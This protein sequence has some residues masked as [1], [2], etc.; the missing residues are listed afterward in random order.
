MEA[1]DKTAE[2]II[3]IIINYLTIIFTTF[4]VA[5]NSQFLTLKIQFLTY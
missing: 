3:I 5:E 4:N 2:S 1:P